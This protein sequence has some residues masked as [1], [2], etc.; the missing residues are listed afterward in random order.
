MGLITPSSMLGKPPLASPPEPAAGVT[1]RTDDLL[2]RSSGN[3]QHDSS[4]FMFMFG[5]RLVHGRV[6]NAKGGKQRSRV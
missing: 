2:V 1:P 6:K 3:Q 4:K 5:G